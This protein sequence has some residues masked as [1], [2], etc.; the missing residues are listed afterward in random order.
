MGGPRVRGRVY[1]QPCWLVGHLQQCGSAQP[2]DERLY[3]TP[4]LPAKSTVRA[5]WWRFHLATESSVEPG[6]SGTHGRALAGISMKDTLVHITQ[7]LRCACAQSWQPRCTVPWNDVATSWDSVVP[8]FDVAQ[9]S[10]PAQIVR[11]ASHI[12]RTHLYFDM[13]FFVDGGFDDMCSDENMVTHHHAH[14]YSPTPTN[15]NVEFPLPH[16]AYLRPG[17]GMASGL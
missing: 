13:N 3:I 16:R 4:A 10:F 7:A 1:K 6:R 15:A 11:V 9:L 14:V 12:V 5:R 2:E 17:W 8:S